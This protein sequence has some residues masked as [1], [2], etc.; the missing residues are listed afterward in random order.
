MRGSSFSSATAVVFGAVALLALGSANAAADILNTTLYSPYVE[1]AVPDV[2]YAGNPFDVQAQTTFTH[3]ESGATRTTG[4]FYDSD[5]QWKFRFSG[6]LPG[7]WTFSSTSA[8]AGLD[9][10]KGAVNVAD[11]TAAGTAGLGLVTGVGNNWAWQAG[12]DILKP[13]VPQLVMYNGNPSAF[14]PDKAPD[15][16]KKDVDEFMNVH[17]F[18]GFHV[19]SLAGRWFD[20]DASSDAIA[21]SMHN[22]DPR[23]FEA[24][25]ALITQTHAA[26]GMVH[27]WVWGDGDQTPLN[28]P[29]GA[30]GEVD[31]RLQQYIAARLG[32]LPGWTM[33]YGYDLWEWTDG[34][35]LEGWH[36]NIKKLTGWQRMLSA[37]WQKNK[38]TQATEAL[39]IAGYE[40]HRPDYDTYT[41][42][43]DARDKPALS[44][45][46]F[47]I[48]DSKTHEAKDYT[49]VDVRKGMWISTMAG[50]VGNIWGNVL[51][52]AQENG[53]LPFEH[54]EWSRTWAD[55]FEKPGRFTFDMERRPDMVT[56]NDVY[57]LFD[58]IA[59]TLI[60]YAEN[61]DSI[62]LKLFKLLIEG[63]P[64]EDIGG[65]TG[66]NLGSMQMRVIAVDT[67][68]AYREIDLGIID[69]TDDTL[70]VDL[71]G[72]SDWALE[73][74]AIP[75]PSAMIILL[76]ATGLAA[77]RRTR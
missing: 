27:I 67:T 12:P 16:I 59:G 65:G 68:E 5:G 46:R 55:F 13:F 17:G 56:G 11:H 32:P 54:P 31:Q 19:P 73:L 26:G 20:F 60:V 24:L 43:I 36:E 25:E 58:A 57:A 71:P 75:E 18:N 52:V 77:R 29:G 4:V 3:V 40:Q 41:K 7:Q 51:N 74:R 38:L 48:R 28:L 69:I 76:L 61:T 33:G 34:E 53:S 2:K 66:Q 23:T 42:T 35:T 47:R 15:K 39:D 14:H 8:H 1:W 9:G 70:K 72:T 63:E 30:N 44:E 21:V 62:Q 37:R 45:D 6:D 49:E 22:P 64:N 10:L 50:G